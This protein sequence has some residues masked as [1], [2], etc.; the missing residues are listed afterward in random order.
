MYLNKSDDWAILLKMKDT[1]KNCKT[2][3]SFQ[4]SFRGSSWNKMRRFLHCGKKWKLI[5]TLKLEL[6][7][8][9]IL[10]HWPIHQRSF[11]FSIVDVT[12]LARSHSSTDD[13][14][15]MPF[16]L[17]H[18][19]SSETISIFYQIIKD[20]STKNKWRTK[21]QIMNNWSDFEFSLYQNRSFPFKNGKFYSFCHLGKT[22]KIF[23]IVSRN[24]ISFIC[25]NLA[26]KVREKVITIAS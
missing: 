6:W 13:S 20:S 24:I 18:S 3:E 25:K 22:L 12:S 5:S 16:L 21:H 19:P 23:S 7:T 11:F 9:G 17:E 4:K 10:V 26:T 1:L 15:L 8:L 2:R 14:L